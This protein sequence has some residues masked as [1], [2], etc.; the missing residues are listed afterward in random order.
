MGEGVGGGGE[1][2]EVVG[3]CEVLDTLGVAE[4]EEDKNLELYFHGKCK[5]VYKRGKSCSVL[6][7]KNGRKICFL[8]VKNILF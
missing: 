7:T 8:R 6:R 2:G 4:G 3:G 1:E 5:R